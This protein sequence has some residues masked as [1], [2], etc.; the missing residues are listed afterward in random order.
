MTYLTYFDV[1]C[2][3]LFSYETISIVN[4]IIIKYLFLYL[5][6]TFYLLLEKHNN[7][8]TQWRHCKDSLYDVIIRYN[9]FLFY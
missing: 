7:R 1:K 9:I 2:E 4:L 8:F 5:L 3:L 6:F